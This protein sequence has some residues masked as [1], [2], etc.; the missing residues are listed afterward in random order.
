MGS[1]RMGEWVEGAAKNTKAGLGLFVPLPIALVY[2]A[3]AANICLELLLE[4]KCY[5]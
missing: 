4:A 5:P 3:N 2:K 1:G